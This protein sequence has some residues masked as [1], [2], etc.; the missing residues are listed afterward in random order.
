MDRNHVVD[1]QFSTQFIN[2][3]GAFAEKCKLK[4]VQ[5]ASRGSTS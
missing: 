4:P 3:I 1:F 2:E 5:S